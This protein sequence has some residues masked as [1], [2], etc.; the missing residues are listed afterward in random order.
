MEFEAN[1]QSAVADVASGALAA[2]QPV[3]GAQ[4]DDNQ[5]DAQNDHSDTRPDQSDPQTDRADIQ[6][7]QGDAQELTGAAAVAARLH[8]HLDA[9]GSL[10]G[11]ELGE[12]VEFYQRVHGDLQGALK[13]I[14][15]A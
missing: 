5:A 1:P 11:I 14:D 15:D 6:T 8:E 13:D 12:H 7:D 10:A 2:E 4:R 9:V 3:V